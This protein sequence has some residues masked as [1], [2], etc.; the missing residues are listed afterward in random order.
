MKKMK[1]G[2][3]ESKIDLFGYCA[4]KLGFLDVEEDKGFNPFGAKVPRKLL[5]R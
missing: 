1:E 3:S 4:R 2:W 5:K